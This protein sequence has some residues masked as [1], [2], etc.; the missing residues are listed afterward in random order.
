L[1]DVS[2]VGCS[3]VYGGGGFFNVSTFS[4]NSGIASSNVARQGG[5]LF[6]FSELSCRIKLYSFVKNTVATSL[7]SQF[8]FWNSQLSDTLGRSLGEFSRFPDSSSAAGGGVWF[9]MLNAA[10]NCTFLENTAIAVRLSKNRRPRFVMD[11][12]HA[13]GSGMFIVQTQKLISAHETRPAFLNELVF[14]GSRQLCALFCVAGGAL[15]VGTMDG[16]TQM[17]RFSF[18][19]VISSAVSSRY[20]GR[21]GPSVAFGSCI[22]IADMHSN[23]TS[24]IRDIYI[25]TTYNQ[26]VGKLYG[27][28]I[29]FVSQLSNG[30]IFN[31]SMFNANLL[32]VGQ[33][34]VIYGLVAT[35]SVVN[36]TISVINARNIS[37]ICSDDPI[38][39]DEDALQHA[40]IT[41]SI[42]GGV[43]YSQTASQITVSNVV[44]DTIT[45]KS[46]SKIYGGVIHLTISRDATLQGISTKNATLTVSN[47]AIY[48]NCEQQLRGGVISLYT[49][50]NAQIMRTVTQD[51]KLESTDENCAD[52]AMVS[53]G[54]LHVESQNWNSEGMGGILFQDF[55]ANNIHL[56]CKSAQC[57]VVG[58]LLS[59]ISARNISVYQLTAFNMSLNCSGISCMASGIILSIGDEAEF[60]KV[61]EV[62]TR[63]STGLC[64]GSKC[65]VIG[66]LFFAHQL[67]MHNKSC[68]TYKTSIFDVFSANIYLICYGEDCTVLGGFGYVEEAL[69]FS[70][71][72]VNAFNSTISS[73]GNNSKAGGAFFSM[74]ASNSTI[75]FG[76]RATNSSVH[77]N[78]ESSQ[79]LGGALAFLSGNVSMHECVFFMSTVQC[80]GYRCAAIGGILSA[81]STLIGNLNY[82][83]CFISAVLVHFS[84]GN[85]SCSG[86]G[87]FASGGAFAVAASYRASEWL[88]IQVPLLSEEAP[89]HFSIVF[90]SCEFK[91]NSVTTFST[92]ASAGGGA[93]S[94]RSSKVTLSNCSFIGNSVFA[95]VSSTFAGGGALHIF[96]TSCTLMAH[97]CSFIFNDASSLGQGGAL[98]VAAGAA[99]SGSKLFFLGNRAGKGGA[100]SVDASEVQMSNSKIQSNFAVTSGGGIFCSSK[101]SVVFSTIIGSNSP[102][103]STIGLMNVSVMSNH[104]TDPLALGVGADLFVIGSVTFSADNS[105][106]VSMRG[107]PERDVTAVV[108]SVISNSPRIELKRIC[109]D[110]TML[111]IAPTSLL[112][113]E[114]H[115]VPPSAS[116]VAVSKCFPACL[117]VPEFEIYVASSGF[118]AS[119]TPCPRGSYNLGVSTSVSDSVTNFCFSCPFGADCL[120]GSMVTAQQS[121]W[122]WKLSEASLTQEFVLLPEGYGCV[123]IEC[124]NINSCRKNRNSIL[125]G[126]C[127]A[128]FSAAFFTTDCVADENCAS[129]KLWI[130]IFLAFVYALLYSIFLRYGSEKRTPETPDLTDGTYSSI[131]AK[132]LFSKVQEDQRSSAFHVLMW[133]YQL[134][135]IL[136]SMPNP[137][138][139]FDEQSVILN[140][141]GL[142]FG[143]VPVSQIFNL[144]SLVFCTKVGSSFIDIILA[145]IL[146]Y[147]LWA[148]IL[149]GLSFQR[150]WLPIFRLVHAIVNVVPTFWENYEN[151]CEALAYLGNFGKV[152]AVF[153]A[154]KWTVAGISWVSFVL[155]TR[156][157]LARMRSSLTTAGLRVLFFVTCKKFKSCPQASNSEPS[158]DQNVA[159][160][161]S[162][163]R[164]QAWLNFGVTAFSAVLSLMIQCT[165]CVTLV[166]YQDQASALPEL[167]WFYDGRVVCFSDSGEHPGNWQIAAI[168][169]VVTL[170]IMPCCLTIYMSRAILKPEG[171][172][173]VFDVSAFSTYF[174]AYKPSS[175]HWFTVL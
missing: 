59:I 132:N 110:G 169:A 117:A 51:V 164:G 67:S 151:A 97:D 83:N 58:G 11:G 142:I 136:L 31:V 92:N 5:G 131:H 130:L 137:L 8:T 77:S 37:L 74:G 9:H 15:F 66:G 36:S 98:L 148:A 21:Y 126:G 81:V 64:S 46:S 17:T 87:C 12:A 2:F 96:E 88:E 40:A 99:F 166:G 3:A 72:N 54:I 108:V 79:A 107:N 156:R 49:T 115:S 27:G 106:E 62:T 149:V 16:G 170:I 157:S 118:L 119:C 28:C 19:D 1:N 26:A 168:F 124:K 138:K 165:T 143:I 73:V 20:L 23:T 146:F 70:I 60:M 160:F 122:G 82:Y 104:V 48:E 145:N 173:N 44:T 4:A 135:G 71:G 50:F 111:R 158:S 171:T 29:S 120:G 129:W 127:D 52:L 38:F 140:I 95:G 175:Q 167:R 116:S 24:T 13:L 55:S 94:M 80:F 133:Y 121:Y 32:A 18:K 155:A 68:N 161:P 22:V 30:I 86:I 112:N 57:W 103:G 61:V 41:S 147:A 105:S 43:L 163:V 159:V 125:C 172:L 78:G 90:R 162:E 33:H 56:S 113:H 128:G 45:M 75:F 101:Q 63:S 91:N 144:P 152:F 150:V 34:S 123:E 85:T 35:D 10:E 25:E 154:L 53:G 100:V 42:F 89:P 6:V 47:R 84:F 139:F 153:V 76:I 134:A 65:N 109:L 102:Q 93:V 141:I 7:S 14:R 69:C 174:D 39:G 114:S